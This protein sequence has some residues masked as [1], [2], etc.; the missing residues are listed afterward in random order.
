MLPPPGPM[1]LIQGN[2]SCFCLVL[3]P[4]K[5][6]LEGAYDLSWKGNESKALIRGHAALQPQARCRAPTHHGHHRGGQ[7]GHGI[8][9]HV[10]CR[11]RIPQ[12]GQGGPL[13]KGTLPFNTTPSS[14]YIL[15]TNQS[16]ATITSEECYLT[17]HHS[18]GSVYYGVDTRGH[19]LVVFSSQSVPSL[20]SPNHIPQRLQLTLRRTVVERKSLVC[21]PHGRCGISHVLRSSY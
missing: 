11:G 20:T 17:R 4:M 2:L 14:M 21:A 8:A 19:T 5:W 15:P 9:Q 16:S 1:F 12:C 3:T 13:G 7:R 18:I 10:A 6:S